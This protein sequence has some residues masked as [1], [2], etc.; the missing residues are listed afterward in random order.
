MRA[1]IRICAQCRTVLLPGESRCL[2]CG[3]DSE[4]LTSP[5]PLC[6]H[7][8]PLSARFCTQCGYELQPPAASR[9]AP[10]IVTEPEFVKVR[11]PGTR[12]Y[13]GI[14]ATVL[15]VLVL[16]AVHSFVAATFFTPQRAVTGY[17]DALAARDAGAALSYLAPGQ[18]GGGELLT[19]AVLRHEGYRPPLNISVGDVPAEGDRRVV[20]VG[21]ELDG[22]PYQLRVVTRRANTRTL[23]VFRGWLVEDG[24]LPLNIIGTG[25]AQA[26]VNGVAV[27]DLMAGRLAAFPGQYRV[28]LVDNPLLQ[29]SETTATVAGQGGGVRLSPKVKDSA[30]TEVDAQV[31]SYVDECARRP[32]LRPLGCPFAVSAGATVIKVKWAVSAYPVLTLTVSQETGALN[33]S[34]AREGRAQVTGSFTDDTPFV[35]TDGFRVNGT[36]ALSGGKVRFTPR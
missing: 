1:A 11:N 18:S 30:R 10:Q 27:P 6:G 34:T 8:A 33:V 14:G 2:V 28:G 32:E 19:D 29:V 26:T 20:P 35:G 13:L 24:L 31:R 7:E 17:F 3:A 23:G 4:R 9:A 15:V 16:V 12:V 21:F 5:C 25:G 22:K 36:A